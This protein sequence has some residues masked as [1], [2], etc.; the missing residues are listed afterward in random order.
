MTIIR[1]SVEIQPM[2][3]VIDASRRLGRRV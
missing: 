3:V 2:T 1:F